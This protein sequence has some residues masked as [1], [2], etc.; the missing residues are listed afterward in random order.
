M[1]V[2]TMSRTGQYGQNWLVIWRTRFSRNVHRK[3]FQ[4]LEPRTRRIFPPNRIPKW[5]IEIIGDWQKLVML[6]IGSACHLTV[7]N[8]QSA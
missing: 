2:I 4:V 1:T 5:N 7:G 3:Q 8:H 6:V